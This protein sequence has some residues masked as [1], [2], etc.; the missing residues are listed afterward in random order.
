MH[1]TTCKLV[2]VI[3][4]RLLAEEIAREI[5]EC[6][7]RGYTVTD[8]RGRG[9]RGINPLDWEGA[10][11]R[12]ETLVP[13]ETAGRIIEHLARKYFSHHGVIA[14]LQDVEVVRG[15]KFS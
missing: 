11:V 15:K 8:S 13:P 12:L 14:F 1:T 2:T 9:D 5:L 4:D 7:A 3:V 10:N 6:G